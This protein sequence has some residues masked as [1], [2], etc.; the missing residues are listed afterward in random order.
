MADDNELVTLQLEVQKNPD[1]S[2]FFEEVAVEALGERRYRLLKSPGLV[3]GLAAGDEI[4]LTPDG[5]RDHLVLRRAGNVAVQFFS[6][7]DLDA[8]LGFL[9][10]HIE[11]LGGRLDGRSN[12]LLVFT[13]PV[14]AG[15][16][17]IEEVF[18]LAVE[19]LPQS[20][21]MF[22]NVYDVADGKTPLNWW[23]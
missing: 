16:A 22:G 7:H 15:F 3:P 9:A 21:W 1:G 2:P 18:K 14:S 23:V 5:E 20:D 6:R 12:L 4:E 13:I 19:R 11:R 17:N 8:C 10:P